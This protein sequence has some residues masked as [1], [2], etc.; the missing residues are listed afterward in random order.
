MDEEGNNIS[1][2]DPVMVRLYGLSLK[3]LPN[4]FASG[5][6][7]GV[8]NCHLV[9]QFLYRNTAC[10]PHC[11]LGRTDNGRRLTINTRLKGC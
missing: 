4:L 8:L 5:I 10:V 1:T 11:D 7:S 3:V 2:E 6:K 9:C